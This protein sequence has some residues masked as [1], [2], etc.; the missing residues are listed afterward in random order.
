[1]RFLSRFF[2]LLALAP[3]VGCSAWAPGPPSNVSNA[4]RSVAVP[5]E[6][7]EAMNAVEP[8]FSKMGEAGP[9]DWLA[10]HR[11][12]G[13]TFE[14]YIK[15][16]PTLPTIDRKTIYVLPLGTLRPD[17]R[18]IVAQVAEFLSAFYGLPVNTLDAAAIPKDL[19]VRAFRMHDYPP[20]R[21]I[22]TG[23]ILD[24]L[25][26]PRLPK[27]AAAMI[28]LTNEDLY[29]DGTMNYVFGQASLADRVGVWSLLRLR[30]RDRLLFLKRAL[31]IAVHETGHMFSMRH[32]TKFEC[33]MSGSNHLGETD[34]HPLDACPECMAKI[35][36]LSKVPPEARYRR[37]EAV[38]RKFGLVGEANEF[39]NKAAAVSMH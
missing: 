34:R 38:S 18:K 14:E 17:D 23:Y 5:S 6:L 16:D 11:E 19:S 32:C 7:R 21:Q 22:K 15:A 20:R 37:L 13:Q 29:P 1:M 31:K 36:W 10:S 12:P 27:D 24:E 28:A 8:F 3:L 30:D 2:I 35:A 33:V 9:M 25:M 39:V 26:K 4:K